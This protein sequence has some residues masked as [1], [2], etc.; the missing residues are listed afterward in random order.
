[1]STLANSQIIV[2]RDRFEP[3]VSEP[4]HA[5]L[6][7]ITIPVH[8]ALHLSSSAATATAPAERLGHPDGIP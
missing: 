1:M 3:A 4:S 6:V 8:N 5:E 7:R 2:A